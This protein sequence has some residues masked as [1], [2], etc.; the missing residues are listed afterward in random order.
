[1]TVSDSRLNG[2]RAERL[3][4]QH[5]EA[6]A[7]SWSVG[8]VQIERQVALGSPPFE[9]RADLVVQ[10]GP[11]TLVVE[12]KTNDS[13]VALASAL[14]RLTGWTAGESGWLPLLIVPYMTPKGAQRC[15]EA[16]VW[17]MDLS[18]NA[19]LS[20]RSGDGALCVDVQG[21][22]SA[23][24]TR[25][26]PRNA[27][28][29]KSS[30][31]VRVLLGSERDAWMQSELA[32][33]TGLDPGHVSR[34]IKRLEKGALIARDKDG[35]VY[36]PDQ[37]RLLDAWLDEARP[38]HAI[39]EGHVSG[40]SGE[41]RARRLE[42]ALSASEERYAFTGLAAGWAYTSAASFRSVACFVGHIDE[43]V[44]DSVGFRGE[45]A[46][47]NVRLMVPDDEGVYHGA[48]DVRGL[49]CAAPAQ[50]Y[51]DLGQEPERSDEMRDVLMAAIRGGLS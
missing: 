20:A 22:P 8:R 4:E 16:G 12:V 39:T 36:S 41:E 24:E 43:G 1:M 35:R 37:A 47:P 28:A 26:R 17:W 23:F 29:A 49:R 2:E 31:L 6:V 7:Q 5:I 21:K 19:R 46:S 44:L 48:R 15:E 34:L 13:A 38:R 33:A 11:Y 3:A 30:R 9:G 14:P 40:K 32:E 25:G 27:F 10:A 45:S 50:V 42:D 18:G 51:V